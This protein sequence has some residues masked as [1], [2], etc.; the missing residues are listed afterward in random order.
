MGAIKI[1]FD[2]F[3]SKGI[4]TDFKVPYHAFSNGNSAELQPQATTSSEC[5]QA[6]IHTDFTARQ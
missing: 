6:R 5:G 4:D 3:M 1:F 2:K